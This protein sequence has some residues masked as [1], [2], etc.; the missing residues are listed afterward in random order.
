MLTKNV[1]KSILRQLTLQI[2]VFLLLDEMTRQRLN[3]RD[4]RNDTL[5]SSAAGVSLDFE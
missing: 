4:I 5:Q 3:M 1:I 2:C